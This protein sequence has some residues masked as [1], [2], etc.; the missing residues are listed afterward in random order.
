MIKE[1]AQKLLN[2]AAKRAKIDGTFS[3]GFSA[4]P[5]LCDFQCN[6]CFALAKKLGKAPF[7]IAEEIVKNISENKDFVFSVAK[8]AFINISLTQDGQKKLALEVE[9]QGKEKQEKKQT[10]FIDYGGPNIGKA[11]HI[12]HMRSFNIGEAF[13]RLY[14]KLGFKVISDIFLGDWGMPMGL[15]MALLEKENRLDDFLSG[16]EKV[17]IEVMNYAYPKASKIKEEDEAFK[18][19]AEELTLAFQRKQQP[20]FDFWKELRRVSVEEI[21]KVCKG[22]NV[23]FDLWN[24]ESNAS[25]YIETVINIFK[26]KGLAYISEGA[27]VVDVA[28]EGEQIPIPKKSEDEPQRYENPMPP[29]MIQKSNG[30]E[31]YATSDIATIYYRNKFYHPD[32][33]HYFTDAR[34]SQRFTQIFRACK[35]AGISPKDQLLWHTGFGTLNGKDGKA[36]KTRNGGNVA[37]SDLL[38]MLYEKAGQKLEQNGTQYDE[39]LKRMIGNAALKFADLSNTVEKDYIFDLDRFTSFEGKTGPYIQYT[40]CRIKSILAKAG[41]FE[42]WFDFYTDEQKDVLI[43]L[44]KLEESYDQA[45]IE[46]SL[47]GIC[48]ALYDLAKNFSSFYNSEHILSEEDEKK[49][50]TKLSLSKLTLDAISRACEVL[51]IELPDKM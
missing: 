41:K 43:S 6:S 22:I 42:N 1:N 29:L 15:I 5:K 44:S 32:I 27:L 3:V 47:S 40:A 14:K 18:K 13:K 46:K 9:K 21:K 35:K 26:D 12:G 2:D 37:L 50:Q 25:D 17:T 11:M 8:P 19:R 48:S 39:D 20:Y 34:Q 23:D 30:G 16:K 28:E 49:K 33:I 4:L 10:I 45:F 36:L 24:G 51:A 31:L 7:E 38:E